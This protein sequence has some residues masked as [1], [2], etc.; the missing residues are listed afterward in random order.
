ML[1]KSP[2]SV[3]RHDSGMPTD[4]GSPNSIA[5]PSSLFV[6]KAFITTIFMKGKRTFAMSLGLGSR[7]IGYGVPCLFLDAQLGTSEISSTRYR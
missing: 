3:D 4:G 7:C 6:A 1:C 5:S 2:G